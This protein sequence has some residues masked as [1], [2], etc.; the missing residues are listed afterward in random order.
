MSDSD[1]MDASEEPELLGL[2]HLPVGGQSVKAQL[3]KTISEMPANITG[4]R[5]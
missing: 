4:F 3:F 1:S 5:Q 2:C